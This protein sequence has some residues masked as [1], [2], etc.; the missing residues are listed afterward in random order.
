MNRCGHLSQYGC[1]VSRGALSPVKC[2]LVS[3]W[4]LPPTTLHSEVVCSY[5]EMCATWSEL[6]PVFPYMS[7]FAVGI[8]RE[9]CYNKHKFS[10]KNPKIKHC[11]ST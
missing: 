7:Q 6:L 11:L 4:M 5:R 10:T 9:L 8:L 1:A 3:H 2:G